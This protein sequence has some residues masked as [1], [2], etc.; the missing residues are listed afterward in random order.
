MKTITIIPA[1]WTPYLQS[2]LRIVTGLLLIEHGTG[3]LLHF[4]FLPGIGDMLG[5]TLLYVT[6]AIELAGG[7]LII[8]G[9]LTRPAA[10][11][12]SGFMAVAYF[13]AHFPMGFFPVL[14]HGELAILYCFVFLY[15]AAAGPGP[16]AID[17]A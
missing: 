14:N 17:K 2:I 13:M 15:F 7:A 16:W 1:A 8:V 3:K 4:P 12:L 9:F 10:F 6:G 11:I 5:P